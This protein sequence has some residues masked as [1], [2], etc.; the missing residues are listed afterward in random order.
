MPDP[1]QA[2]VV[3]ASEQ[4]WPNIHGLV[5]WHR[6][7]GG[8]SDLCIYH[9]E[10]EHRSRLP[11][12]R[13]EQL[14]RKLYDKA[15]QIHFPDQSPT[16]PQED[17]QSGSSPGGGIPSEKESSGLR[18]G[19]PMKRITPQAVREQIR[20]WQTSLPGRRWIINATGGNKLMFAGALEC[21]SQPDTQVV[22]RELSEQEW[23]RI[24]QSADGVQVTPISIPAWETDEIPVELLLHTQWQPP[25]GG[26]WSSSKPEKLPIKKLVEAGLQ[27]NWNWPATFAACGFKPKEQSGFLFEKFVAATLLELGVSNVV[28][29][30]KLSGAQGQT[31]QEIDIIANYHGRLLIIDCKLRT[32]AKKGHRG[33]GLTSQIRQAF[34][35]RQELGGLGAELL[36]LRPGKIFS[37][38]E[39]SLAAAYRLKTLDARKTLDFFRQIAQFCGHTEPLPSEFQAAQDRLDQAKQQGLLE[40]LGCTQWAKKPFPDDSPLDV[41]LPLGNHLEALMQ[42]LRQDWIAYQIDTFVVFRG[43]LPSSIKCEE[44]LGKFF[45]QKLGIVPTRCLISLEKTTFLVEVVLPRGKDVAALKAQLVKFQNRSLFE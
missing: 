14:C 15:I 26:Y 37:E 6:L 36:L 41:I 3:L 13:L 42:D 44:K 31:L 18:S 8:L 29:N 24:D 27:N 23:Y 16:A 21:L 10:D 9:T 28:I 45:S 33:E 4:L 30:A 19:G 12:Q 11:A 17:I 2:M 40:A 35:T 5:H 25:Q 38:E 43:R 1:N 7:E 22:Y 34:T 20:R 32:N 39:E